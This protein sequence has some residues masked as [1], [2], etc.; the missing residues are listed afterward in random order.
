MPNIKHAFSSSVADGG[1]SSL[2]QPSNWNAEHTLDTYVD[3]P[4]QDTAPSAPSAAGTT[5]VFSMRVAN[6]PLLFTSGWGEEEGY[7]LQPAMWY[8]NNSAWLS[9]TGTSIAQIGLPATTVGTVSTPAG[10]IGNLQSM[11]RRF[12]VTSSSLAASQ[13]S[14]RT[15]AAVCHRG[16]AALSTGSPGGFF[17]TAK[18]GTPV[19]VAASTNAFVGLA[20]STGAATV[21]TQ[22]AALTNAIG[23]GFGSGASVWSVYS[24]SS[25]SPSVGVSLAGFDVSASA[26]HQFYLH[27]PPGAGGSAVFWYAKN[28]HSGVVSSGSITSPL[29]TNASTLSVQTYIQS[30]GAGS[31]A[32]AFAVVWLESEY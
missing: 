24:A 3:F 20:N 32:L 25:A 22:P 26:W 4:E 19:I 16:G 13:A 30:T 10:S 21:T 28:L 6:H 14:V 23:F 7:A 1:N 12:Q 11:A 18:V 29:P 2:V 27:N 31:K 5:R 15:A 8:S 9:S 17:F